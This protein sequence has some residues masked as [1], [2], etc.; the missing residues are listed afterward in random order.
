MEREL[1]AN[2]HLVKINIVKNII[3]AVPLSSE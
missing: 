3:T 1:D 2:I